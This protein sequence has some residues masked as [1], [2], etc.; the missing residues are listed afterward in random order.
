MSTLAESPDI[1]PDGSAL[2][3]DFARQLAGFGPG[4]LRLLLQALQERRGTT[5]EQAGDAERTRVLGYEINR[6]VGGA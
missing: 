4:A 2:A 3:N 5:A 1:L 6:R